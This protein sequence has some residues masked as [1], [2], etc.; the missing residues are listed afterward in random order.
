MLAFERQEQLGRALGLL[1]G[2][3]GHRLVEQQQL[4][5]L[6][7]QHAD[8]EP[9]LLAVAQAA[10]RCAAPRAQV[11]QRRAPRRCGRAARR[12]GATTATARTRRSAASAS[13][14]FSN[15]LS[16]SYTVGFWNLR[17][18]PICAISGSVRRSRSMV[19]PKNTLPAS[20]RVLPVMHVHH[21]R[22]AGAVGADDA[23]QLAHVDR[24]RQRV[25]RLEAVEADG[26]VFQVQRHAV[27]E[28]G[29]AHLAAGGRTT[30][31]ARRTRGAL[32]SGA[33]RMRLHARCAPSSIS[34]GVMRAPP[35]ACAAAR[36][37]RWA[38][39]A[40]PR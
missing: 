26:D 38:G 15:T 29:H 1:V 22:L 16:S 24:E 30:R 4:G 14:R 39:T 32:G 12:S 11:D 21:R 35:C 20:G 31:C 25:Q 2:H 18:M 5:V 9:L 17:P 13:S 19:E 36:R 27:R 10:R 7:Q 28:V 34:S 40:S 23:A 33:A 3:A 6:H 37:C 8:L